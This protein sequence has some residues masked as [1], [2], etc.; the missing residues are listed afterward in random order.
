MSVTKHCL[1]LSASL[2]VFLSPCYAADDEQESSS[3]SSTV[4][5]HRTENLLELQHR[6]DLKDPE[7]CYELG[8]Y[9]Y[10][11]EE[12]QRGGDVERFN[13]AVG[14]LKI[15]A[16]RGHLKAKGY[17]QKIGA[18]LG[19]SLSETEVST[20]PHSDIT[21]LTSRTIRTNRDSYWETESDFSEDISSTSSMPASEK[22][23]LKENFLSALKGEASAKPTVNV[24]RI[25]IPS[26]LH[27][28]L[29]NKEE[30]INTPQL[31]SNHPDPLEPKNNDSIRTTSSSST[32]TQKEEDRS[33]PSSQ[34]S[35]S[36]TF[37]QRAQTETYQRS[38]FNALG[39]D[40]NEDTVASYFLS[41]EA[42]YERLVNNFHGHDLT[43]N[44][45]SLTHNIKS[46]LVFDALAHT[47]S[48][49][50]LYLIDTQLLDQGY[51]ALANGLSRNSSLKS[52]NLTN[53]SFSE[54]ALLS[55]GLGLKDQKNLREI[56][57][58]PKFSLTDAHVERFYEIIKTNQG[59]RLIIWPDD[60]K[61]SAK[62][63]NLAD[64]G[65][66]VA[67]LHYGMMLA[68]NH[69]SQDANQDT[70]YLQRIGR[71]AS[72]FFSQDRIQQAENY[73]AKAYDLGHPMASYEIGRLKEKLALAS[74]KMER[75]E[76]A[77]KF[78]EEALSWYQISADQN[79]AQGLI[80]I[81][82]YHRA[83]WPRGNS[84]VPDYREAHSHYRLAAEQKNPKALY[85]L[86][87]MYE[88]G[89]FVE[90]SLDTAA[91]LFY[92]AVE[93]GYPDA[94]TALGALYNNEAYS[95]YDPQTALQY[96]KWGERF[97]KSR[98][99]SIKTQSYI[100]ASSS[101]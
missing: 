101:Q 98:A 19:H 55:L 60:P 6:A 12:K 54:S 84:A 45:A 91:Y 61:I 26:G 99:T 51:L 24:G 38:A 95:G 74:F 81:G 15:A 78:L 52:I 27:I 71:A 30:F 29:R 90:K 86:G 11:D 67:A 9:I 70:S 57:L 44:K 36:H 13:L 72:N 2:L 87:R 83:I 40:V 4:R 10:E 80:K 39:I 37:E 1:Y 65:N 5:M 97:P 94:F 96:L 28:P 50:R 8:H 48:V 22:E 69:L 93:F 88:T 43:L 7:A 3:S 25:R 100:G 62:V 79:C 92:Q 32:A 14:Y 53:S 76:E 82:D 23:K 34:P 46:L 75:K 41:E 85:R 20:W 35:T 66:R 49:R 21:T 16:E 63:K 17:L 59:L 31:P 42:L 33:E 47:K 73:L 58:R 77:Q 18:N 56:I 68:V 89:K 64:K